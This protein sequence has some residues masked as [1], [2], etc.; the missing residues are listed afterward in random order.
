MSNK[1]GS[2]EETRH[3]GQ[4]EENAGG[5]IE[6][7][8]PFIYIEKLRINI[9]AIEDSEIELNLGN[10]ATRARGIRFQASMTNNFNDE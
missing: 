7:R 1:V 5:W 4:L 8:S 2:R 3:I 9:R 10:R 6:R